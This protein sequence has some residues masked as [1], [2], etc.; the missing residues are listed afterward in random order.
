MSYYITVSDIYN[1]ICIDSS[2]ENKNCIL[3]KM[4]FYLSTNL[5]TNCL[6]SFDIPPDEKYSQ[7]TLFK[8]LKKCVSRSKRMALLVP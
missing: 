7:D 5:L 1:S 3:L 2:V 6:Y 4:V 8:S